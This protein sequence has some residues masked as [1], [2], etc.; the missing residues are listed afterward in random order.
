MRFMPMRFMLCVAAAIVAT[1]VPA[2]AA[3]DE[4]ARLYVQ[5]LKNP[6][7]TELNL[8]YAAL[9]L[10][11]GKP[12]WALAAY[13]RILVND[14]ANETAQ[15]GLAQL[16]RKLVPVSTQFTA[17]IGGAWESNPRYSPT[18]RRGE[19]QAYGALQMRDERVI[20]D[21]PWRTNANVAGIVHQREGDLNYGYVGATTG[22]VFD[23]IAGT[24]LH[25]AGGGGAATFDQRFYY[26]EAVA[27][28]TVESRIDGVFQSVTV[29]GGYRDY[30]DFFPTQHGYYGDIKA[31]FSVRNLAGTSASLLVTPWARWSGIEGSVASTLLMEIQPGA[32]TEWGGR[33]ELLGPIA[34]G[35]TAG[36]TFVV[37]D[38][39]YRTDLVAATLGKR[40]DTIYGPGFLIWMPDL[41]AFQVGLKVEYQYLYDRSN[42]PTRSFN[43]HVVTTSVVSRF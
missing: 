14:P 6:A 43:D 7:N 35:V 39:Y 18:T 2:V 41:F 16:R 34:E 17:E 25:L 37:F 22:P 27:A 33:V 42:D 19:L 9:A 4:L 24:A 20:G 8:R 40:H 10:E 26:S 36:P 28:A 30:N 21:L 13:E 11:S 5:I 1:S 32:Y 38:R 12:R 29:R 23:F 31:K 15:R 3:P